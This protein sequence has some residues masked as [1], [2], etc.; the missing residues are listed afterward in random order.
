LQALSKLPSLIVE[1]GAVGFTSSFHSSTATQQDT[2]SFF[3]M[4]SQTTA[5]NATSE[6]KIRNA[7]SDQSSDSAN[8]DSLEFRSEKELTSDKKKLEGEL[9][10]IAFMQPVAPSAKALESLQ[11]IQTAACII[12]HLGDAEIVEDQP[13]V[14]LFRNGEAI[15]NSTG[16]TIIHCGAYSLSVATGTIAVIRKHNGITTVSNLYEKAPNS[17][18]V[19]MLLDGKY[20]S[21]AA[22]HQISLGKTESEVKASIAQDPVSR[23]GL[24]AISMSSGHKLV[25]SEISLTSLLE[26]SNVLRAMQRSNNTS[27]RVIANRVTKMAACLLMVTAKRGP[28]AANNHTS[29]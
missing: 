19:T 28:Y 29:W 27:D 3:N 18:R 17:V 2:Q 8:I 21:I 20:V 11:S 24:R 5:D 12:K 6:S 9:Q 25:T 23:R 13:G 7:L 26:N 14:L 4:G 1:S 22:G 16:R 10:P 15:I